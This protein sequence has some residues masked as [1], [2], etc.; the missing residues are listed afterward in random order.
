M[1]RASIT[2]CGLCGIP[3]DGY[4]DGRYQ[5]V[6][7]HNGL[8]VE[9]GYSLGGWGRRQD[10]IYKFSD[11]VCVPCY[12]AVMPAV[13]ALKA[14]MGERSPRRAKATSLLQLGKGNRR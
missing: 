12:Q 6:A 8:C 7:D 4:L 13:E 3:L 9:V 1:G 14:A 2:T 5:R 11:E 10:H